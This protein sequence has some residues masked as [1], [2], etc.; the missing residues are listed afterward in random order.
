MTLR[1][2]SYLRLQSALNFI[3]VALVLMTIITWKLNRKVLESPLPDS[4][5]DYT[6]NID[7]SEKLNDLQCAPKTKI[8]FLKIHKAAS[9]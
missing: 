9:R 3:L 6:P 8:G 1:K 4:I 7:N 2:L 5:V